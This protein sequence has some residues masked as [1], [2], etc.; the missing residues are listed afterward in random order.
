MYQNAP[1]FSTEAPIMYTDVP[2]FH[3]IS[4]SAVLIGH[5]LFVNGTS[6]REM[7]FMCFAQIK[8]SIIITGLLLYPQANNCGG[9][10]VNNKKT[11]CFMHNIQRNL[12]I[13]EEVF[14]NWFL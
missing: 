5:L 4:I 9:H 13:P 7:S 6:D 10:G 1:D 2:H 8:G 3:L 12:Y 11:V 14:C